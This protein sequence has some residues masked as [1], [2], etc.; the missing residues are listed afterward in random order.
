MDADLEREFTEFVVHRSQALL[1]S[2]V[3]DGDPR[4]MNYR[5]IAAL[6][7]IDGQL[8]ERWLPPIEIVRITSLPV[9]N[10]LAIHIG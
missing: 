3:P 5:A 9:L 6:W 1:R 4:D 7:T 8:L 2:A 10:P